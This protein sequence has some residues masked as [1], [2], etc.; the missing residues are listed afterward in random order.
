MARYYIR[1]IPTRVLT[2]L[3]TGCPRLLRA[4]APHR[5]LSDVSLSRLRIEAF[6]GIEWSRSASE[7]ARY[8]VSRVRP[9]GEMLALREHTARTQV[10]TSGS[11][12]HR[13]SQSQR[14][15]RWVISRPPRAYTMLA[16]RMALSQ[17]Q[18]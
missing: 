2:A 8:I 13:L 4:I 9:S 1:A 3:A 14:V 7:M 5:T 15:L 10:A 18:Q 12:W 6:P 16:V 11:P 17:A